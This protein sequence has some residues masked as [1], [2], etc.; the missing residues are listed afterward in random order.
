M[1]SAV[2]AHTWRRY[3]APKRRSGP[4]R[5]TAAGCPAPG[6]SA[7]IRSIVP[8]ALRRPPPASY[9]ALLPDDAADDLEEA[10]GEALGVLAVGALG[11]HVEDGLVG[12]GQQLHPAAVAA[13]LDAVE[14]ADLGVA[15]RGLALQ[16]LGGG[17]HDG[18]LERP[19]ARHRLV[20]ERAGGDLGEL[21]AQRPRLRR[22]QL[23]QLAQAHDGVERRQEA[24]EDVA[25][26]ERA[27]EHHAVL[28]GRLGERRQRDLG[29]HHLDAERLGERL[30]EVRHGERQ[31]DL[32]AA[33][34]LLRDELDEQQQRL[35]E[36]HLGAACRR[37][38]RGAP[39]RGR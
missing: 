16:V 1:S 33:G 29:A 12:V 14:E 22:E 17:A 32:L 4:R 21:L 38:R 3:Q 23:E 7:S 6:E 24:R 5:A 39:R 31:H 10:L 8:A 20:D 35:L 36:R 37:R 18:A 19:R 25:A 13:Q 26:A 30:G 34:G 11:V 2:A 15:V 28:G 9:P 27:G